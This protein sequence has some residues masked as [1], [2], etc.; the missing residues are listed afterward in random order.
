MKT[1]VQRGRRMLSHS[2]SP[3]LQVAER[4]ALTHH[5]W[6]DGSGYLAGLRGD[7]IPLPGRIVAIA[8][9][10][11]ALTH[12]RPYKRAMPLEMALEEIRSLR[13]ASSTRSVVDAFETLPHAELLDMTTS[14]HRRRAASPREFATSARVSRAPDRAPSAA[15]R[16]LPAPM[17]LGALAQAPGEQRR[18][19]RRRARL[20]QHAD[21]LHDAL[22]V[23]LA[24]RAGTQLTHRGPG[25]E[26]AAP[27]PVRRHRVVGVAHQDDAAA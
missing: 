3:L 5:E 4:I 17:R 13:G 20:A 18:E 6:W 8:D 2:R 22:R 16:T 12:D 21:Q 10:F 27:R 24:A 19:R 1:H 26:R 11:D 7:E 23:E 15:A 25:L 14:R 9:V